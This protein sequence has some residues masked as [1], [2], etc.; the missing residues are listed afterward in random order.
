[1]IKITSFWLTEW[2]IRT[3][4]WLPG[5][6]EWLEGRVREFG[7]DMHT[8][9]YSKWSNKD[10]LC[11]TGNSAQCYVAA[12]MAGGFAGEWR[13]VSTAE[14][15]CCPPETITALFINYTPICLENPRDGGAW[16][17]AV[18]G[19][20]QSQT[21]LKWLSIAQ[22][23]KF[24]KTQKTKKSPVSIIRISISIS[25]IQMRIIHFSKL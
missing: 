20:A 10:R 19:V 9:L 15:L 3:N 22:G 5:Q 25:K 17:A 24:K 11:S 12:W 18:Y 14:F 16:W 2:T 4:L 7:M 23:K 6:E 1:M 8:L 13:R 21:R